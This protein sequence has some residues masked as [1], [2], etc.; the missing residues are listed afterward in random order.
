MDYPLWFLDIEKYEPGEESDELVEMSLDMKENAKQRRRVDKEGDF[1]HILMK[2]S[3]P[4][5]LK[6]VEAS[7]VSYPTTWMVESLSSAVV[8]VFSRKKKDPNSRG[9]IRLR[10]NNFIKI[11]Y[12]IS[13]QNHQD[14][15]SH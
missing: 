1:A 8:D 9:T 14:Q 7:I 13:C 2:D 4:N 15:G 5:I 10:L 6:H 12:D 11:D 3:H